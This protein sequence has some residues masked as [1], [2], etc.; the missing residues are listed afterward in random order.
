M[1]FIFSG[2]GIPDSAFTA[3]S[4]HSASVPPYKARI[5]DYND[6]DKHC[7]WMANST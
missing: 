2:R 1:G 5:D 6:D 4:V 3:N 7:A